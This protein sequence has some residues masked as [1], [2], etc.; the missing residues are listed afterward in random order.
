MVL[1]SPAEPLG[2][3]ADAPTRG[4]ARLTGNAAAVPRPDVRGTRA[5]PDAKH[6]RRRKRLGP[7]AARRLGPF[8]S[9]T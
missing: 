1:K 9:Q 2:Q 8:E 7:P 3:S 6:I 4:T 5:V